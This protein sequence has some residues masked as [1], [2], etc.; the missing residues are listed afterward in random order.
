MML[1]A[2][3]TA[4]GQETS[5]HIIT[6]GGSVY[7]GGKSGAVFDKKIVMNSETNRPVMEN[8]LPK[9][10]MQGDADAGKTKVVIYEGEIGNETTIADGLGNVF[11]G[12]FGPAARVMHTTVEVYGGTIWNSLHGGGEIAAVGEGYMNTP[13]DERVPILDYVARQG[14]TTIKLYKG[15]VKRNVFGGG[16]GYSFAS[17]DGTYSQ[18]RLYTDGYVFGSTSVNIYGGTIGD[19]NAIAGGYGNVFGGGDVGFVYSGNSPMTAQEGNFLDVGKIYYVIPTNDYLTTKGKLTSAQV[20][21]FFADPSDASRR[22]DLSIACDVMIEP[23]CRITDDAPD[24]IEYVFNHANY[25]SI[26]SGDSYTFHKGDYVP[27][28]LLNL[29]AKDD[30][31]EYSG[32]TNF[33]KDGI[34]I[35]NAVFAGGN[36]S[37]GDDKVYAETTTVYGNVAATVLDLYC[38]DFVTIGTEHVGGLYGDGNLT[39]ADGYREL[40]LS[41]YGTDYYHLSPN[42]DEAA[43]GHLNDREKAFYQMQYRCVVT[44]SEGVTINGIT[45]HENQTVGES[46]YEKFPDEYKSDQY[47]V[48]SGFRSRFAGRLMNTIQRADFAGVFGCRLVLQG[49]MDRVLTKEGDEL[50][51]QDYTINRIG[52]LSLNKQEAPGDSEGSTNCLGNYFGIYNQVNYLGALTSD[53]RFGDEGADIWTDEDDYAR[54]GSESY[55]NHKNTNTNLST[56]REKNNGTSENLIALASGVALELKQE[57]PKDGSTPANDWGYITGVIQLDLINVIAGEGGGF[58]YARNE[59]GAVTRKRSNGDY[60]VRNFLSPYNNQSKAATH[61]E[62]VYNEANKQTMQTSGNFVYVQ[63]DQ[64]STEVQYI[65]DDCYPTYNITDKAHYWYIKGSTY[66]YNVYVSVYTGAAKKYEVSKDLQIATGE[67]GQL[68]LEHVYAGYYCTNDTYIQPEPGPN[69]PPATKP[70][71]VEIN[72]VTYKYGDP[73]SWWDYHQLELAH[74]VNTIYFEPDNI[75]TGHELNKMTHENGFVISFD[76]HDDNNHELEYWDPKYYNNP[77]VAEY[78]PSFSPKEGK[79]GLYGQ[80][81]YE[82]GTIILSSEEKAHRQMLDDMPSEEKTEEFLDTQAEVEYGTGRNAGYNT[83]DPQTGKRYLDGLWLCVTSLQPKSGGSLLLVKGDL[84]KEEDIPEL[85]RKY[86]SIM[87]ETPLADDETMS[88]ALAEKGYDYNNIYTHEAEDAIMSRVDRC[89]RVTKTGNFGGQYYSESKKYDALEGWG[90]LVKDEDKGI[91]DRLNWEFNDDALDLLNVLDND[92]N[93]IAKYRT[94]PPTDVNLRKTHLANIAVY[95]SRDS[96]LLELKQKKNITAHF[97]YAYGE[98]GE[99]IENH[100][101]NITIDFKDELPDVG[102]LESPD[103]ILP[104]TKLALKVPPVQAGA[105]NVTGGGWEY[106]TNAKDANGHTNGMEFTNRT[107]PFYWYQDGYYVNYYALTVVGRQYSKTPVRINVANYHDLKR[108]VEDA[109]YLGIGMRKKFPDD[110]PDPE[111]AT[112]GD[113]QRSPKVYINDYTDEDPDKNESGLDLLKDLFNKTYTDAK[114]TTNVSGCQDL[115]I[116]MRS[117]LAPKVAD[118]WTTP[119]GTGAQCFGGNLHGDGY[120]ISGLSASLFNKLCGNVYNLGVTGSFSGSGIADSGSGS[121]QNCWVMNEGSPGNTDPVADSDITIVNSY[122][123]NKYSS[124]NEGAIKKN[125]NAFYNGNVAYEVN[126]YHLKKEN[127]AS[128]GVLTNLTANYVEDRYADGDFIYADGTIPK[129]YVKD[130]DPR[131]NSTSQKYEPL[132]NYVTKGADDYIFFGQRL[133]YGYRGESAPHQDVPTRISDDMVNRVYRA[134]AYFQSAEVSKAYYNKDAVFAAKSADGVH[135]VYPGMTAIDFTGNGTGSTILDHDGLTDF[136]NADLTKNLLVYANYVAD[137]DETSEDDD[138]LLTRLLDDKEPAFASYKKATVRSGDDTAITGDGSVAVPN[139]E[140][141]ANIKGHVVFKKNSYQTNSDHY[142]VDRQDYF[143]PVS[144]QMASGKRMWYQRQPDNYAEKIEETESEN[145]IYKSIGWESLSL[146][147]TA[148]LVTT[149]KKGEITHFYAGE[150]KGHEYWLRR[151]LG[152]GQLN[153]IDNNIFEANFQYPDAGSSAKTVANTFLWDYYYSKENRQ[154]ANT[155]QYQPGSEE[156]VYHYYSNS[157]TYTTYPRLAANTPYIV[158]FPGETYYEFDLSGQFE[159]EH[160]KVTPYGIGAQTITFASAEN[161]TIPISSNAAVVGTG[162]NNHYDFVPCF[163]T[164]DKS[165]LSSKVYL[166][167]VQETEEDDPSG[168]IFEQVGDGAYTVPFRAY[169]KAPLDNPSP[170]RGVIF[171]NGDNSEMSTYLDPVLRQETQADDGLIIKAGLGNI[172]VKSNLNKPTFVRIV[173]IA[174]I[175]LRSFTIAPGDTVVTPVHLGGIYIVNHKKIVVRM[176]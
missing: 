58:V 3:T 47:W 120:T 169:F 81:K 174:G 160:A 26:P 19:E 69:D 40:S 156:D 39:F 125:D 134:P 85:K 4:I 137:N 109:D 63:S 149:Q 128:E 90:L 123:N 7:G 94:E 75:K 2:A 107:T 121:V 175:T 86:I 97:V 15:L 66:A 14:T 152:T 162:D 37:T 67:V 8:G 154:D 139:A 93:V 16:R 158:G 77:N 135:T 111:H 112:E 103:I 46:V 1:F 12:G 148:E 34:I 11:G 106:Y 105:Y 146:P 164:K 18:S 82:G 161:A 168:S 101:V 44:S 116:I 115:E 38:R 42:I 129:P 68:R 102:D 25:S 104:G 170:S 98:H 21:Y 48:K 124:S 84:V 73:I 142:L 41:C 50:K 49:A 117:D 96:R 53:V 176:Y 72:G 30:G 127:R 91:N 113:I 173:N 35:R 71:E 29:L 130:E 31:Y 108:A 59:H 171:V 140:T 17:D 24:N 138:D 141:I 62:Y 165:E 166:L 36:V 61:E 133:T 76:F 78:G 57:P 172:I 143:A 56:A 70:T 10:E 151:Y 150:T 110:Y 65:V 52:E 22:G 27:T 92:N 126:G 167:N 43:Y 95:M 119:I 13:I 157:R 89:C 118:S 88:A 33:D 99:H 54:S 132:D 153:S 74:D 32:W 60:Y 83:E 136:V 20:P 147:F 6:I 131:W 51:F 79:S 100:Y 9:V 145:T 87:Y 45:Y 163:V 5:T 64:S 159:A 55:Y 155:D 114:L 144:Y 122:Y 23:W 28:N 80:H